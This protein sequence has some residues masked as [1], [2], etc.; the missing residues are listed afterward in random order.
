MNSNVSLKVSFFSPYIEI[1]YGFISWIN[2]CFALEISVYILVIFRHRKDTLLSLLIIVICLAIHIIRHD[3]QKIF[4][5]LVV[6]GYAVIWSQ[7][8]P[9]EIV[10][11]Y[12]EVCS[13]K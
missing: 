7:F 4:I 13:V 8:S 10:T 12:F 5:S 3:L 9:V 11:F 6:F 2:N 1:I